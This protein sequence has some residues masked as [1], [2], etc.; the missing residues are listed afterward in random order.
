MTRSV[1]RGMRERQGMGLVLLVVLALLGL[2]SAVSAQDYTF[3]V[4]IDD[5]AVSGTGP[6]GGQ[7]RV[8][9]SDVN[10]RRKASA[11][12]AVS[13][14]GNWHTDCL[15]G[16]RLRP[17]DHVEVRRN[18]TLQRLFAI[19]R[20]GLVLDRAADEAHGTGPTGDD[21]RLSLDRCIPG[22]PTCY[23]NALEQTIHTSSNGRFAVRLRNDGVSA[24]Y[25]AVGG[26][27]LDFEWTSDQGDEVFIRGI[28]PV[29]Q[30]ARGSARVTGFARPGQVVRLTLRSKGGATRGSATV[31]ANKDSGAWAT[32]LRRDGRTVTVESR[33]TLLGSFAN[34]AKLRTRS[35]EARVDLDGDNV[36]G[37]CFPGGMVG[38][39]LHERGGDDDALAWGEAAPDRTYGPLNVSGFESVAP[40]WSVHL[41]CGTK[42][43]DVL[44]RRSVVP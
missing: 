44:H 7:L 34:D 42:A 27:H 19:P 20:L 23:G 13:Q 43:N 28:I 26:E 40:G 39:R 10:D 21:L 2:P 16:L 30:A 33:D 24:L 38:L 22:E 29:M 17:R 5:C 25:D 37:S 35:I 8:V 1:K 15:P 32:R 9:V 6:A 41:Y 12:V 14:Q 36:H 4:R 3:R 18:G 11:D 31:T